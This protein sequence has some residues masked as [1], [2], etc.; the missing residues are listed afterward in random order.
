MY[1]ELKEALQ[2][3]EFFTLKNNEI[4]ELS[5]IEKKKFE[6]TVKC[7]ERTTQLTEKNRRVIT[8]RGVTENFSPDI[9]SVGHKA[10]FFYQTDI[11]DSTKSILTSI[12]D[13]SKE[14][15][16]FVFNQIKELL[17]TKTYNGYI[18]AFLE[19]NTAFS[20]F[21]EN[22]EPHSFSQY[23]ET[24]LGERIRD[25]Y[26]YF[27]HTADKNPAKDKSFLLSTSTK[28]KIA[29]DFSD[30]NYVIVYIIP[31]P[32]CN[33]SV[34]HLF[35]LSYEK[36]LEDKG[37]PLYKDTAIHP[38]EDEVAVK[39][40]LFQTRILGV[41][42][43]TDIKNKKFIVNPHIFKAHNTACSIVYDRLKIEFSEFLEE[44][45]KSKH[46]SLVLNWNGIYLSLPKNSIHVKK[47]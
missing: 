14:T 27:L 7:L 10:Q 32:L 39:G 9:F 1:A 33:F 20:N 11:N 13:C 37:F 12:Q 43:I 46:H 36:Q 44:F 23:S 31:T 45:Y 38:L 18:K 35:T 28:Y 26:L 30:D 19:K 16:T 17:Q 24:K 2:D 47:K 40:A 6:Q 8:F 3:C 4:K 42:D 34:T 5:K 22:N 29:E 41:K 25:Y 15:L 21:F